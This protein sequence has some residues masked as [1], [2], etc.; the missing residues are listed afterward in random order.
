MP[1]TQNQILNSLSTDRER[2]AD[3]ASLGDT[4]EVIIRDA[5]ER[6]AEL[7]R[8]CENDLAYQAMEDLENAKAKFGRMARENAV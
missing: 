6:C 1:A 4:C 3:D 8:N 7:L 5:Y 2:A